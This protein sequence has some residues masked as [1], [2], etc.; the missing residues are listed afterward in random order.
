SL[1]ASLQSSEKGFKR[2]GS[3]LGPK[4]RPEKSAKPSFGSKNATPRSSLDLDLD[5]E[6]STVSSVGSKRPTVVKLDR[7]KGHSPARISHRTGLPSSSSTSSLLV[8]ATNTGFQNNDWWDTLPEAE[9]HKMD[10]KC[11]GSKTPEPFQVI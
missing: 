5:A 4:K 1:P 9:L 6:E 2:R 11:R 3:A 8:T 10:T 7:S